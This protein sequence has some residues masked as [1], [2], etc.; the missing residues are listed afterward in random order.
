[1]FTRSH[2][3]IVAALLAAV[4]CGS[5][6]SDKKDGASADA[7]PPDA[8][9]AAQANS[10][11]LTQVKDFITQN[12]ESLLQAAKDLRV[13]APAPDD[14]GWNA[15]ADAAAVTSMKAAW[16]KA[17]QAYEHVEG[18]IAVLFP[19]L[20]VATDE[21]YDGFLEDAAD[22]N[23]FD[24]QGVTGIH[25]IERILW[26]GEPRAEVVA[27]E[28]ALRGYKA[29]EVPRTR[30]A[31]DDFKNKLCKRLVDDVTM[32]RDTFK[33]LALDSAAAYR[34]VIGSLEEQIEKISKAETGEEESRYANE[35]LADMRFNIEGGVATHQ[36]FKPWLLGSKDGAALDAR[37]QAGFKRI[38]D[39][40]GAEA[41]L[42]PVPATW[43]AATP[44]AAD[45]ATPFGKLYQ[46]LK[47]ESDGE[48]PGSLVTAMNQAA[49]AMGIKALP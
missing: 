21:R 44:S 46:L 35:T 24:D 41:K 29:A 11:A 31:A 6:E 19:E 14:D 9:T 12:L 17:R 15:T 10:V 4:A 8:L 5:A 33:P 16:R 3:L 30:T 28:R 1:M 49:M 47:A 39:A 13:A 7:G 2:G 18:A 43:N 26:A 22:D 25:A 23:L 40:Y 27:F 20:D 36:A 48:A 34:G 37:I 32:M 38:S 45:L 42:P